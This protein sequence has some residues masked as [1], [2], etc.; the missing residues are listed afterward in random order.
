MSALFRNQE[1]SAM[2]TTVA[3]SASITLHSLFL[4]ISAHAAAGQ[5]PT[6]SQQKRV[7]RLLFNGPGSP[8][9]GMIRRYLASCPGFRR[10]LQATTDESDLRHDVYLALFRSL[11]RGGY[12]GTV[13][14]PHGFVKTIAIRHVR[15]L[16]RRAQ[17]RWKQR[18][19]ADPANE[20]DPL[21]QVVDSTQSP[22]AD[23]A[24]T[25]IAG[26][27]GWVTAR[28]TATDRYILW[29]RYVENLSH[30]EIAQR[31]GKPSSSAA[32][33][34]LMR[35]HRRARKLFENHPQMAADL[36]NSLQ[37]VEAYCA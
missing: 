3:N 31:A 22:A 1:V 35:A 12:R 23:L 30:A 7:Y 17:T 36:L 9:A 10:Y 15:G 20:Y 28:M 19:H 27:I 33:V 18:A 25:H 26:S 8:V 5:R 32:R 37:R 11:E 4:D 16:G 2:Q 13:T 14:N 21:D 24:R 29:A 6:A 34:G